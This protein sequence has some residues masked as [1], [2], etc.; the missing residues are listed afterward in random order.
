[1]T[2]Y[3]IRRLLLIIPTILITSGIIFGLL[4]ILPADAAEFIARQE[5]SQPPTPEQIQDVRRQ[6]G[7]DKPLPI[8]YVNFWRDVVTGSFGYSLFN[9]RSVMSQLGERLPTSLELIFMAIIISAVWG[10]SVGIIAALKQDTWLDYIFR[11]FA[12]AGLSVPVFWSGILVIVLPSLWFHWTPLAKFYQF[13]E[14]PVANFKLM[15]FPAVILGINL[16]APVMRMTRTMMLEVMRQDYVRTARAKGLAEK[17][18]ILRHSLQNA[19]I[20]VI[21]ILGLQV[22]LGIGGT[23][24]LETVFSI[25]GMGRLLIVTSLSRRD[26]PMVQGITLFIAMGV[27]F[28]NLII[29]LAYGVIDPR[30]R[31]R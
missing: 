12:I 17:I 23:L 21:T 19:L 18:V 31:Y 13:Y 8:Q 1:M 27:V 15:I 10:I 4:R 26:Y 6:L 20:P 16:G 5:Q 25:P 7:L 24:V 9:K 29:D 22:I 11:S 28:V 14:D 3:V 30:V 2:D